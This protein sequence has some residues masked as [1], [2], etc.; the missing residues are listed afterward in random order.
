MAGSSSAYRIGFDGSKEYGKIKDALLCGWRT[1]NN[2]SVL[3]HV[4]MDDGL[5]L[6]ICVKEYRYGRF[7]GDVLIGRKLRKDYYGETEETVVPGL[8]SY[9]GRYTSATVLWRGIEFSV[10]S[11]EDGG[12]VLILIT[13]EK[14]QRYPAMLVLEAAYLWNR[15]GTLKHSGETVTAKSRKYKTTVRAS[16]RK[17]EEDGNV[18]VDAPYLARVFD[19]PTA[20]YTGRERTVGQI[21][22]L[23]DERRVEVEKEIAAHGRFAP[24][25]EIIQTAVTWNTA[26]DA[27]RRRVATPTSRIWSIESG[28]YVMYC[29]DGYFCA[30][31]ASLQSKELAYANI[32]EITSEMT[33]DGFVPNVTWG[34]GYKSLDRSQPPVGASTLLSLYKKYGDVWLCELLYPAMKRWNDWYYLH[35]K[36]ENGT[37][38]WGSDPFE[39]KFGTKWETAG[40]GDTYGAALESGMDNSPMYDGIPFD[41]DRCVMMLEDVGLTGLFIN[42]C[43][44]MAELAKN[45]GEKDDAAEFIRRR[46]EA[47]RGLA[48]L[49]SEEDGIYLN[50]RSDTGEFSRRLSPTL[51]YALFDKNVPPERAKRMADGH[52]FNENEFYG[53][54]VMPTISRN[55]AAFHE[56]LYWRGRIWAPVN[57]LVYEAMKGRE[58]LSHARKDLIEKSYSLL[59]KEWT[60]HRHVHENYNAETGEGCD[61]ESSDRFYHWGA[62]LGLIG[63]IEEEE[64]KMGL[65]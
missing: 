11:T 52:Y 20:F 28:G 62:L 19:G 56:Q 34:N 29:W 5:A 50:R 24:V 54:Y 65:Q 30:L 4:R 37:F 10:E 38:S 61:V 40:V 31:L 46:K 3:S 47:S 25:Y 63:I 15:E 51:F 13:P 21:R 32:I 43:G 53:E 42:D 55:D 36:N 39:G 22:A 44:A 8:H 17:A 41:K 33:C 48:G 60:E 2:Y 9:D 23:L 14:T 26:Y 6:K 64:Q 7:L 59:M 16:G 35:R 58:E 18:P 1:Y 57:F 27:K 12:D 49:W 45:V